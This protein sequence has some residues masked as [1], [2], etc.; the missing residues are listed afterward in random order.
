M[1]NM[2]IKEL[3]KVVS[4]MY[5]PSSCHNLNGGTPSDT[6]CLERFRKQWVIYYSERGKKYDIE[7]YDSEERACEVF[8]RILKNIENTVYVNE[9]QDPFHK[10]HKIPREWWISDILIS[11]RSSADI[12]FG[13]KFVRIP[14][15]L[16]ADYFL[17]EP[18]SMFWL[19]EEDRDIW[20]WR[21]DK[22]RCNDIL[23]ESDRESVMDSVNDYYMNRRDRIIFLTKELEDRAWELAEKVKE[24]E[25]TKQSAAA[26]LKKEFPDLPDCFYE[27]EIVDSLAGVRWYK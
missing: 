27:Y 21:L 1:K 4:R 14:G 26:L 9:E 23:S 19:K 2:K 5:I 8:Y 24:E 12:Y 6:Y 22:D 15:E 25:L 16:M 18:Y 3:K 17:A 11:S 10:P 20:P 7:Y 13:D